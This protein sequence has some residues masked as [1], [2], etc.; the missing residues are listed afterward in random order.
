MAIA[1]PNFHELEPDVMARRPWSTR[2][3]GK[4]SRLRGVDLPLLDLGSPELRLALLEV[5]SETATA[6]IYHVPVA[7]DPRTGLYVDIFGRASDPLDMAEGF[8]RSSGAMRLMR[9]IMGGGQVATKG[10]QIKFVWCDALAPLL[11]PVEIRPPE[12]ADASTSA[13]FGARTILK[14][15]GRLQAGMGSDLEMLRFLSGHGFDRAPEVLGWFELLGIRANGT[16]GTVQRLR[17][18]GGDGRSL[19]LDQLRGGPGDPFKSIHELGKT[20]GSMHSIL[21]SDTADPNFAPRALSQEWV[22][23]LVAVLDEKI[24]SIFL[25]FADDPRLA[26]LRQH[27]DEMRERLGILR[28]VGTAGMGIRIHGDLNLDRVLLNGSDWTIHDFTG[29]CDLSLRERRLRCSPL[30]DV[31]ALLDSLTRTSLEAYPLSGRGPKGIRA[32]RFRRFFLNG[33]FETMDESLL[34]PHEGDLYQLLLIH[35]LERAVFYLDRGLRLGV[36]PV[37][38]PIAVIERL[39][40]RHQL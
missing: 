1:F 29:D 5:W 27:A 19:V 13:S 8:L 14:L 2:R 15:T 34:P 26:S 39:L 3:D 12:P 22:S 4:P 25:R 17:A 7:V 38:I 37:D 23:L 6:A 21:A 28:L 31:A 10:G 18:V 35:E 24:E 30:R 11:E 40:D 9:R 20:I 36:G 32:E 16:L 33:Y